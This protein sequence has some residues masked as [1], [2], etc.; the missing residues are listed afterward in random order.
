M[1][2]PVPRGQRLSLSDKEAKGPRNLPGRDRLK[3][4]TEGELEKLTDLQSALY[5]DRRYAVLVILQGRD[6]SGKDG[7]IKTVFGACNPQG[8]E[9][10]GFRAPTEL[11]RSHDFLWR[12]HAAVPARGMIGIFN[13]SHYEDVLVVRVRKLAPQSVWSKRYDQ[14]NSFEEMLTANG[15]IILKFFL[16]MS[17]DE[18][19]KQLLERLDDPTKNW[20]FNANDLEERKLWNGYTAAYRDALARCS[21]RV[22]PWYVVPADDKRARNYL[23]ARTVVARLSALGLKYPKAAPEVLKLKKVLSS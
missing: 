22:A 18:Q 5:A 3:E 11:E 21:T 20:K 8:V 9:V 19:R 13:R 14:I 16:H 10:T 1:L 2:V 15:V 12:I 23:I 4:L 17:R 7:V 6:A